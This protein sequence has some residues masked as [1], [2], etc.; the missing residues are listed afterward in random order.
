MAVSSRTADNRWHLAETA[1]AVV[2]AITTAYL[3]DRAAPFLLVIVLGFLVG[4]LGVASVLLIQ[5]LVRSDV[6]PQVEA[7][8]R[9]RRT[10]GLFESG[11]TDTARRSEEILRE[12]ASDR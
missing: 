2:A 5:V 3:T 6:Q 1:V 10:S 12:V 9:R 4:S 7:P 8:L 11:Y